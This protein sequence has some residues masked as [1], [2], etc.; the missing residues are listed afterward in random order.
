MA[1]K[2][3]KLDHVK[4]VHRRG[5]VYAYFNTGQK[6]AGKPIYMRMPNPGAIGFY[7]SYA[8]RKNNA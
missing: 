4:Y 2:L 8:A 3:P 7:D 5:R 1:P 6:K